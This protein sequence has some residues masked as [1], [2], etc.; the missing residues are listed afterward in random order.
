MKKSK[1]DI[2]FIIFATL[3]LIIGY[4]IALLITFFI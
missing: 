3:G 1:I 2:E 4:G